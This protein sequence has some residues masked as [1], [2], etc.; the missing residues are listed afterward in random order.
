MNVETDVRVCISSC[1]VEDIEMIRAHVVKDFPTPYGIEVRF[2]LAVEYNVMVFGNSPLAH[3]FITAPRVG[4]T[5]LCQ[6]TKITTHNGEVFCFEGLLHCGPQ[7]VD[8]RRVVGRLELPL[9]VRLASWLAP[10]APE[11]R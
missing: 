10:A 11:P 8:V 6:L 4:S 5:F 3:V 1:S 2:G 9:G 7:E